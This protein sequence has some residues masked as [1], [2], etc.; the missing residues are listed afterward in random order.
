MG[1]KTT[2]L[3]GELEHD[4][5]V[6]AGRMS[7]CQQNVLTELGYV[8]GVTDE[9]DAQLDGWWD[10]LEE[11][12]LAES[13]LAATHDGADLELTEEQ[14]EAVIAWHKTQAAYMAICICLLVDAS[15]QRAA[16][17]RGE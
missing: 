9:P 5:L 2:F 17:G 7:E 3:F 8:L 10:D 16:R 6:Q 4:D 15:A 13:L 12:G 14:F 1:S 11:Q